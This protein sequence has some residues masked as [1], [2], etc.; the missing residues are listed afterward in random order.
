MTQTVDNAVVRVRDLSKCFKIFR[1]PSDLLWEVLTGKSKHADFWALQDIQFDIAPGEIIGI[2]GQNG[3][4]KST[5]LKILTGVLDATSGNVELDGRLSAILELGTGFHPEYTGRENI[6]RGG[7]AQGMSRKEVEAKMDSIIDFAGIRDFIDRPFR[8]YSSGMK[9]R[10]TFATATC[11]DPDILIVD[12]AL[13]TGDGYFVQKCLA[14][15]REM[16]RNG[17]AAILVSHSTGLI[18]T[19]CTRVMWLDEGRIRRFGKTIDVVREYDLWIHEMASE[20][21]GRVETARIEANAEPE[22]TDQDLNTCFSEQGEPDLEG[23]KTVF[24]R[25]PVQIERVELFGRDDQ[26]T[27]VFSVGD[28]MTIRVWY[29]VEGPLPEESLGLAFAINRQSDLLCVYQHNTHNFQDVT[30]ASTYHEAPFRQPPGRAGYVEARIES[31]DLRDGEYYLSV[32]LLPNIPMMWSFYEYHHHG[33]E[34]RVA[35]NGWNFGAICRPKV[36]WSHEPDAE[37]ENL[38]A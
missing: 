15:I 6:I 19:I 36:N 34:F 16:C 17:R 21:E 32:G 20:G 29:R 26:K 9:A 13:A 1:K 12:E 37:S 35:P 3:A 23:S 11:I 25:G 2:I 8:T 24:R 7:I 31:V 14:R 38:A 27:S 33:Y 10:L 28:P 30:D 18:G 22:K 5:L 4:G